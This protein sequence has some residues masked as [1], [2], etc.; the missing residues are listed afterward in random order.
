MF[1]PLPVEDKKE[2]E[3]VLPLSCVDLLKDFEVRRSA[4]ILRSKEE[5]QSEDSNN[6][7]EL[8]EE[9]K[10]Q[11]E[12]K[13]KEL[14]LF[15][16]EK[17]EFGGV[18][19]E[20]GR[21]RDVYNISKP[22]PA[23]IN[24][25]D[26]PKLVI[27]GRGESRETCRGS[28]VYIF[29]LKENGVCL[30]IEG[31]NPLPLED[32]F[33]AKIGEETIIGG[34]MTY[35]NDPDNH[36]EK[37]DYRTLFYRDYGRGLKKLEKFAVG[38]EGM[39]DIRLMNPLKNGRIPVFTRP[40]GGENG[41][42]RIAYTELK[43]PEELNDAETLLS[44]KVIENQF[45]PGEW[46]GANELYPLPDGRIGVLGHVAYKEKNIDENQKPIRHYYVMSFIYD[47]RDH[48][49]IPI[50]IIATRENF[51]DGEAKSSDLKDVVFSGGLVFD[52]DDINADFAILY[53]G[54]SD[55]EAGRIRIP[56][57]FKK[58]QK[59]PAPAESIQVPA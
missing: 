3:K 45:A 53:V 1:A 37:I 52:N 26:E 29:E 32:G 36:P 42:G 34:V 59:S 43:K 6:D 5:S 13:K 35:C 11:S 51:P 44:A 21:N 8:S 15:V 19:D 20:N 46:G 2:Q 16:G 57:P 58:Y 14:K 30:P 22:F 40:Q 27:T 23:R 25:N 10:L 50:E 9:E 28:Q 41:P 56:N 33:F 54:L 55:V 31:V 48:S 7:S 12:N 38:P 4:E 24:G 18:E 49:S 47:P 17:L 39:K